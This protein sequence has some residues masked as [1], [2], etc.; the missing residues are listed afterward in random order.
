[1]APL[2]E[3][4]L[5]AAGCAARLEPGMTL[6]EFD[7]GTGAASI[8]LAEE[9][10]LYARGFDN[11]TELLERARESAERSPAHTR[12]RF[13]HSDADGP[14]LSGAG[15]EVIC[16]LSGSHDHADGL[17]VARPRALL[18]SYRYEE[19]RIPAEVSDTF[20]FR[21]APVGG[22]RIWKHAATPLE[23]ERHLRPLERALRAYR[24]R[25]RAGEAVSEVALVADR[26]IEAFR[27]HGAA[28]TYELSV[29][30][31]K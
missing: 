1:M 30:E 23:W 25:L 5:I 20:P 4:T 22:R 29:Y 11:R 24:A 10:H 6:L 31:K 3:E 26:R 12:V 18:G 14:G 7:C 17:L 27:A 15:V 13:F 16:S 28:L 9:F 2:S 21:P 19:S 8:F